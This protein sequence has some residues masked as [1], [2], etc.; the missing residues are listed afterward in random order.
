MAD[1]CI[2]MGYYRQRPRM[3]DPPKICSARRVE[4]YLFVLVGFPW[5]I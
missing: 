3:R 2:S 1:F 5:A 4:K